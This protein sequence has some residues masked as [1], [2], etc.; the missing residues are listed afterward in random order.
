MQ[1]HK[2]GLI[3]MTMGNDQPKY[4][5]YVGEQETPWQ[6]G[7]MCTILEEL[8]NTVPFVKQIALSILANNCCYFC[9]G[10]DI[11]LTRSVTMVHIDLAFSP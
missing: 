6:R 9:Y 5:L 3:Q 1:L 4:A 10:L 7:D 11:D 8:L 2:S